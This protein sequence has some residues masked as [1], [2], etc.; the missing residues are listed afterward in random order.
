LPFGVL[1]LAVSNWAISFLN[2]SIFLLVSSSL[3]ISISNSAFFIASWSLGCPQPI[4]SNATTL[5][6][7]YIFFIFVSFLVFIIKVYPVLLCNSLLQSLHRTMPGNNSIG[8]FHIPFE[9]E[10]FQNLIPDLVQT[11]AWWYCKPFLQ[12]PCS[13]PALQRQKVHFLKS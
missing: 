13:F 2:C 12:A 4:A 3:A 7:K 10:G 11:S 8:L 5:N 1:P 9:P 6:S